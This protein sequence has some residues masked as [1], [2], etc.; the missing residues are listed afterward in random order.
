MDKD[1]LWSEKRVAFTS[2]A[3]ETMRQWADINRVEDG[4]A[5]CWSVAL[6]EKGEILQIGLCTYLVRGSVLAKANP[7]FELSPF[8]IEDRVGDIL[9]HWVA[10]QSGLEAVR[11][12]CIDAG[13]GR[14]SRVI[15]I[16]EG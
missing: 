1:I 9:F 14:P 6:T 10:D 2:D 3:V 15:E 11:K 4:K 7:K 5:I 13:G 16:P 12:Y 8:A